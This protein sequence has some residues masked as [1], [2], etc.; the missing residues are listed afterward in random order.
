MGINS[1]IYGL[2]RIGIGITFVLSGTLKLNDPLG[3]SYKIEEYLQ[4][5]GRPFRRQVQWL[6]P[7]T[8]P[9]AIGVIVLE[10]VLGSALLVQWRYA[11]TMRA[12]LVLLVFFTSITLYTAI[13]TQ[14]ASCGCFGDVLVL[15]P[16]Q[17]LAKS[18]V[19][20]CL[21]IGLYGQHYT[22]PPMRHGHYVVM[23]TFLTSLWLSRYVLQ[24]L[25]IFDVLPYHR[26]ANLKKMTRAAHASPAKVSFGIWQNDQSRT[27]GLLHGQQLLIIAQEAALRTQLVRKKL[28]QLLAQLPGNVTPIFVAPTGQGHRE[29]TLLALPHYTAHPQLLRVLLRASLGLVILKEGIVKAKWHFNDWAQVTQYFAT[30]LHP[31]ASQAAR[32]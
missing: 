11:W 28:P 25:P 14:L 15:T 29:A 6:W 22:M 23:G 31:Q 18:A 16:W 20:L 26:G 17:S 9:I 13:S 24:H 19:L 12:L 8:L 2:I 1:G 7:Y 21:L 4:A 5:L 3:F 32:Q 10:T 30:P 27:A